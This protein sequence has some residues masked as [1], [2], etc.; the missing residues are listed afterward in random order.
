MAAGTDGVNVYD[1]RLVPITAEQPIDLKGGVPV[2]AAAGVRAIEFHPVRDWFALTV[3]TCVRVV[4]LQGHVF[5]DV[6][7]GYG[8]EREVGTVAFDRTGERLATGD[9]SGQIK[10]W[11]VNSGGDL[12]LFREMPGHKGGVQTLA[13]APD[14][15]MLASGG[16][17]RTVML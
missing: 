8:Q 5:V 15:R 10:L 7:S 13:F 11:S 9:A 14:S 3:C 1:L 2:H 16:H 4:N 12:T 6:S 17:D